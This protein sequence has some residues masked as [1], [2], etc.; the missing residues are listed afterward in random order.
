MSKIEEFLNALV[1]V[2]TET[3]GVDESADIIEFSAS[4]PMGMNETI[5]EIGNYTVRYKPTTPVPPEASAIHFITNEDLEECGSYSDDI[6]NINELLNTRRFFIAHNAEFDRLKI[7]QNHKRCQKPLPEELADK[8]AWICTLRFAKKMFGENMEFSNFTLSYLWFKFE[9]YKECNYKVQPHS[10][11]DDVYMCLKVLQKLVDL[12][13]ESGIIDP[14]FDIGSQIVNFCNQPTEFT[15]MPFGKHKGMPMSELPLNYM[16]WMI[17]KSD[18][19]NDTLP[20]FDKDLAYTFEREFSR[21][22]DLE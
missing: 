14:T 9:L 4:F 7:E 20:T 6:E 3:T 2:D 17:E 11:R 16:E 1:I 18:I 15:V 19:L 5:D 13:V 12:A 8:D 21:R 10:A 22:F